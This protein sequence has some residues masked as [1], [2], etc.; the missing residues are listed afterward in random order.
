MMQS[1][2]R[3]IFHEKMSSLDTA[4][5]TLLLAR[6]EKIIDDVGLLCSTRQTCQGRLTR[7]TN[8]TA[9]TSTLGMIRNAELI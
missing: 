8:L 3:V 9:L 2:F 6:Y 4:R 5:D 7:I 1:K